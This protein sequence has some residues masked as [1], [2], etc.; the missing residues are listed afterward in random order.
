MIQDGDLVSFRYSISDS[1]GLLIDSS[2]DTP[3]KHIC[4][5]HTLVPGL[6]RALIGRAAGDRFNI[7]VAPAYGYGERLTNDSQLTVPRTD[8]PKDMPLEVGMLLM[9]EDD[10]GEPMPVWLVGLTDTTAVFDANHPLAG[11]TL[12]FDVEVLEARPATSAEKH[13]TFMGIAP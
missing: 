7:Q 10:A 8:L 6:E 11:V 12:H 1:D 13:R 3:V 5:A 2:G 4:G 9:L